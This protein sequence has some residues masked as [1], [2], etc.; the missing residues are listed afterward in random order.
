MHVNGNFPLNLRGEKYSNLLTQKPNEKFKLHC[1][2]YL[3]IQWIFSL[4]EVGKCEHEKNC[5]RQ[6][7]ARSFF[8]FSFFASF[9]RFSIWLENKL[10]IH[11]DGAIEWGFL[12]LFSCPP[13]C[14]TTKESFQGLFV[15]DK[16]EMFLWLLFSLSLFQAGGCLVI[17]IA[18]SDLWVSR[19]S[20][21]LKQPTHFTDDW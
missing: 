8:Q 10:T 15:G 21:K 1:K 11:I 17:F 9:Y 3:K 18:S 7:A 19:A 20:L 13:S 4:R 16:T 14:S 6:L 2:F 12:S 5:S